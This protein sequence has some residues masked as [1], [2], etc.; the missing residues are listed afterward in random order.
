MSNELHA[1]HHVII[2]HWE[3]ISRMMQCRDEVDNRLMKCVFAV[4]ERCRKENPGLFGPPEQNLK[5]R[6]V[7]LAP[8]SLEKWKGDDSAPRFVLGVE[9]IGTAGILGIS[10]AEPLEFYV[11]TSHGE[12][13]AKLLR[14]A[15]PVPTGF[16]TS[17]N[18]H[19][20]VHRMELP[21]LTKTEFLDFRRLDQHFA[22]PLK[23][24]VEW[25]RANERGLKI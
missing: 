18:T 4:F 25:Y 17:L 3:T 9:H 14:A 20:Y 15:A 19:D 12:S 21:P 6:W 5:Q 13:V 23:C 22:E 11:Y 1:D 10:G 2:E 7:Q 8:V 16:N 24:L